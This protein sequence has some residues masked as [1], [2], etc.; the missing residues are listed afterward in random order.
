MILYLKLLFEPLIISLDLCF[1]DLFPL[2]INRLFL[3]F[4]CLLQPELKVSLKQ[5]ITH[6]QL[7]IERLHMILSCVGLLVSLLECL[8]SLILLQFI[9]Y[10][11]E[12]SPLDFLI[13]KTFHM[14]SVPTF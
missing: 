6:H 4:F 9:L 2:L 3:F 12:P 1:F 10:L 8:F 14:L 7:S 5:A 11:I 13:F